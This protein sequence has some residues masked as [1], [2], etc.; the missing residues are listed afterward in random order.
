MVPNLPGVKRI[1]ERSTGRLFVLPFFQVDIIYNHSLQQQYQNMF[2]SRFGC[3]GQYTESFGR[4]VMS[5]RNMAE[6]RALD[7][8]CSFDSE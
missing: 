5:A 1:Q 6:G 2:S 3:W 4:L 7:Q 8:N